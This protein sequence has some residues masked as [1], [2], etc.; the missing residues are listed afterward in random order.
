LPFCALRRHLPFVEG[1]KAG[2]VGKAIMKR[3]L[4]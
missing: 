3:S 4:S 2:G 1:R